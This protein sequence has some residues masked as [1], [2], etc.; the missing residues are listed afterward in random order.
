[1]RH[2]KRTALMTPY[3][4]RPFS[5][6]PIDNTSEDEKQDITANILEKLLFADQTTWQKRL[7]T[8]YGNKMTLLDATYKTTKYSLPLFFLVVKKQMS[9]MQLLGVL[10]FK[11]KLRL[12]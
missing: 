12:K 2:G 4:F 9:I 6:S 10:S 7:M 11:I 1:M 8:R 5:V 3:F